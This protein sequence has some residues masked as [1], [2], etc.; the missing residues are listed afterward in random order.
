MFLL[1]RI[2][3][4][5][6]LPLLCLPIYALL[7][8]CS[9]SSLPAQASP[10]VASRMARV[11]REIERGPFRAEWA[12]LGRYTVPA[13][14]QDAKFGIFI[15]WGV[16]SVPAFGNEWYSRNM[17]VQGSPAYLHHIATYGPQSRFGYKDFV[18]MFKAEKF[19]SAAWAALFR[20]AGAK[21]IVPVAEHCDGFPMYASD[22]TQWNALRMGPKRDILGELARAARKEGLHFG[23]SSHR[24][25]HWWWYDGG[26]QFD[27]DVNNPRFASLYGP[28]QPMNLPGTP[29]KGEPDPDHLEKW[30][31]PDQAFLE[32]WLARTTE[33]IDK[34]QPE[35]LYLDWWVGQPAFRPYLEKLAAY[36]YN[37]AAS[38]KQGVVLTYKQ[39]DFPENAAVLDIERGK[40][41]SLRLLPWQTDT[42]LSI[43]SWGYVKD[44]QYRD[45][46][47]LI[48]EL[49]DVVSK[50][51][52]LLLNVGPKA[53]GTIPEQAQ[54][55]L[56]QIGDWLRQNGEAI[57]GTRPWLVFGEGPTQDA[58]STAKGKDIRNYTAEDIRFTTKGGT[59][60]AIALGWPRGGKLIIHT[61]WKGTPYLRRPI[62][63]VDLL[64]SSSPLHWE[65][66]ATGLVL[67]LPDLP[68]NDAAYVFRIHIQG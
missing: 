40:L 53:D 23:A 46:R 11:E 62:A 63:H 56:L 67:D 22:L 54:H 68:P 42:S 18:P 6:T 60:Y 13:W 39:H 24:A 37:R 66:T 17:Y 45:A 58:N 25:E 8:V 41:D 10:G 57:Y 38:S 31:P 5:R 47:S 27:S 44:D 12:S 49:V 2:R 1:M 34:Y 51:G 28:A 59:L 33:I 50:N 55:V 4:R 65:Q 35:L 14:F 29:N 64:G 21:Y 48:D 16:Y 19:D 20:R 43:Q 15:H 26:T 7:Y 61:L 32:D 30:L 36:Y 3:T 52:N 9:A